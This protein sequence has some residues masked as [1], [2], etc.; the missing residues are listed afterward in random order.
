MA[1]KK[2]TTEKNLPSI[3]VLNYQTELERDGGE[4][5]YAGW[6][7]V[8]MARELQR[9]VILVGAPGTGFV[10]DRTVGGDRAIFGLEVRETEV[11]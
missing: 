11:E 6:L 10:V 9:S 7:A 2:K 4:Y 5:R 8:K 3:V 1:A